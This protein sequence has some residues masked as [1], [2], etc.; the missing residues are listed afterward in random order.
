MS[1]IYQA[2]QKQKRRNVLVRAAASKAI[3][4]NVD[5]TANVQSMDGGCFVEAVIWVSDEQIE[6]Q[7]CD[8]NHAMPACAD[9]ECWHEA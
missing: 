3:G 7:R 4:T 8:G 6:A 2:R 1:D 5:H 9:T